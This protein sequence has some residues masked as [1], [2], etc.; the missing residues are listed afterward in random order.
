MLRIQGTVYL[1]PFQQLK[2]VPGVR[3]SS[4]W[5]RPWLLSLERATEAFLQSFDKGIRTERSTGAG[6]RVQ[7]VGDVLSVKLASEATPVGKMGAPE[8]GV[9]Y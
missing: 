4:R 6:M 3:V 5:F 2:D 7:K 1:I 8:N 9:K